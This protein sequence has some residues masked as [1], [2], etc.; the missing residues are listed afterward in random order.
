[1]PRNQTARWFFLGMGAF[2]FGILIVSSLL[3][4]TNF[5]QLGNLAQ[6]VR[7]VR[8]EYVQTVDSGRLVEGAIRGL[9]ESLEDPYSIY[10][11]PETFELFMEQVKGSFGGIGILVGYRNNDLTVV[12]PFEDTPAAEAGIRAGDVILAVDD[13]DTQELDLETAVMLM[14]GEVGSEVR[15]TIRRDG[16]SEPL[17]FE[18]MRRQIQVPTVEGEL[19]E[20]NIGYVVIS[21]FA[22]NTGNELVYV[23]NR[24]ERELR[25]LVLDLRDN[26][27]GDLI[28]AVDVADLFIGEGPIVQVN[29]RSHQDETYTADKRQLGIPL[30]ILVNQ[31][32]AS[33]SEIVAG[34]V[35]DAGVGILV[36]AKTY[37]KG[38]VQNV[39][40][41]N[42][43]AGLKLTT[44][45]YLTPSG[46]DLHQ[47]GIEPHIVVEDPGDFETDP[48]L[49]K[50]LELLKAGNW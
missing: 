40:P 33:A 7:L 10:L 50:A 22:E 15:L 39:F 25:G 30:V 45:R 1:M 37:G 28:A 38:V 2:L 48:Q 29:Y 49:D 9:V 20:G 41:L 43:G 19:L 32:S 6:V 23:L 13:K 16:H 27:G 5:K 12:R 4:F 31:N 46:H 34:A 35:K 26:P 8:A 36:G 14:R 24:F 42:N 21:Q 17:V 47:K 3:V 11:E 18:V 44:A